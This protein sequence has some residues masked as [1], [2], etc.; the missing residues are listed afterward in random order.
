[1]ERTVELDKPVLTD[2]SAEALRTATERAERAEAEL[3]KLKS[4]GAAPVT[5]A[6]HTDAAAVTTED[7]K[8]PPSP[9]TA[10]NAP[11]GYPQASAE[12]GAAEVEGHLGGEEELR[13]D[14]MMAHLLDS[15]N[16]GT[17]VGHYG[18]LVFA[19]VAR[20]FLPHEEVLAYLTKDR[21]F[22]DDQAAAMLHQVEGRDYSPPRRERLMEWQREQEFQFLDAAD[23]DSGN[24]YRNLKFPDAIYQHIGHYQEHKS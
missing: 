23:P 6:T 2:E 22:N 11:E 7:L 3:A 15:L 5:S 18:R 10:A 1:M 13:K 12:R 20:H 9:N 24:L 21:D 8:Q 16:A 4:H 17:D 14:P 19:M